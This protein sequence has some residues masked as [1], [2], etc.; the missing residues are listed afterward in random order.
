MTS[1]RPD[2]QLYMDIY[3]LYIRAISVKTENDCNQSDMDNVP[4]DRKF[5]TYSIDACICISK[6]ILIKVD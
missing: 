4:T 6:Q 2:S 5:T 3:V 1:Y